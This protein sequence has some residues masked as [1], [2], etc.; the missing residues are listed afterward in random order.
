MPHVFMSFTVEEVREELMKLLDGHFGEHIGQIPGDGSSVIVTFTLAELVPL[1]EPGPVLKP[2]AALGE[3][4][5]DLFTANPFGKSDTGW[6]R[7]NW[8][9]GENRTRGGE[10]KFKQ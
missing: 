10:L 5:K 4:V 1:F 2:G 6:S 9:P 7:N 3:P 8:M